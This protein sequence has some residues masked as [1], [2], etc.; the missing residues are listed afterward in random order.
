MVDLVSDGVS[1]DGA[2]SE[3]VVAECWGGGGT[4][5]AVQSQERVAEVTGERDIGS[6]KVIS[7]SDHKFNAAGADERFGRNSFASTYVIRSRTECAISASTS[8]A[9]ACLPPAARP[10]H[11]SRCPCD[12]E[13]IQ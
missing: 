9:C 12:A 8:G 2:A 6:A 10:R 13:P 3:L 7:Y 1:E 5:V 11:A 4:F